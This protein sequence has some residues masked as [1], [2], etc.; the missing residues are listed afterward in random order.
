MKAGHEWK[1]RKGS[2]LILTIRRLQHLGERT[3]SFLHTELYTSII[4]VCVPIKAAHG[5]KHT[6]HA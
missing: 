6:C 3:Q 5:T 1:I 4:G 2:G